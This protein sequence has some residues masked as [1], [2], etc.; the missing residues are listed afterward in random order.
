[1]LVHIY[2]HRFFGEFDMEAIL[3]LSDAYFLLEHGL[4]SGRECVKWAEERLLHDQDEGDQDVILLAMPKD[5]DEIK[6][7]VPEILGNYLDDYSMDEEYLVG[8]FIVL[9]YDKYRSAKLT[10]EDLDPT[11]WKLYYDLRCPSW[12]VMLSRNCEY[13]TDMDLFMKPFEDEFA[14]ISDLWIRASSTD[15]FYSQYDR[16]VSN[17]HDIDHT[18]FSSRRFCKEMISAWFNRAVKMVK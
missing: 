10:V 14:Y 2:L 11:F 8:R 9:L 7:L 17:S 18:K 15:D 12:L 3:Q 6:E 4:S 5:K 1:L 13:A 16:K